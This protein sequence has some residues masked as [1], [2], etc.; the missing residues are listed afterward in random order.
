MMAPKNIK[1]IGIHGSNALVGAA[2]GAGVGT[3]VFIV[4]VASNE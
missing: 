3:V 1:P 2:V 4:I